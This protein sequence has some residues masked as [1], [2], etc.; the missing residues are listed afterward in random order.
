MGLGVRQPLF[1]QTAPPFD[2]I[3]I[4]FDPIQA[5]LDPFEAGF[6]AGHIDCQL[7]HSLLEAANA[8]S[9]FGEAGVKLGQ[10]ADPTSTTQATTPASGG[11]PITEN[12]TTLPTQT[13]RP[14][15]HSF[16]NSGELPLQKGYQRLI[17]E[18]PRVMRSASWEE[19]APSVTHP[20]GLGQ[21]RTRSGRRTFAVPLSAAE[22]REVAPAQWKLSQ[23]ISR[24][25]LQL[26]GRKVLDH[27][28]QEIQA[29][30]GDLAD[31][32]RQ[33]HGLKTSRGMAVAKSARLQKTLAEAEKGLRDID[34][35]LH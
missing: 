3:E 13:A 1:W 16:M 32:K 28:G 12:P 30:K 10:S 6:E 2:P 33:V 18:R 22:G 9:N 20:A 15:V 17:H 24:L 26:A 23:E 34:A 14:A 29:M 21:R 27:Q 11:A 8:R 35:A 4:A 31:L 19:A 5:A 7:G 25:D